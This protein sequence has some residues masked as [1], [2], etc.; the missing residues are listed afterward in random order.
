[1][2][3]QLK[4]TANPLKDQF[5]VEHPNAFVK[6]THINIDPIKEELVVV[7]GV[8][9]NKTTAQDGQSAPLFSGEYR[10]SK[11]PKLPIY[12]RPSDPSQ[13]RDGEGYRLDSEGNRIV[14][15][16]PVSSF[17]DVWT[18]LSIVNG[19]I[20]LTEDGQSWVLSTQN[21]SGQNWGENFEVAN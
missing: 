7:Y 6:A 20:T 21:W 17:K 14:K 9:H 15:V 2:N 19:D 16:P 10:W 12:E 3:L 8:F 13:P 4:S 5:G 1:M 11:E 18:N